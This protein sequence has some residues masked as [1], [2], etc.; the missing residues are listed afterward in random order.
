MIWWVLD[1]PRL[2][3]R[4]RIVIEDPTEQCF[5]SAVTAFEIANKVRTGKLPAAAEIARNMEWIM[6]ENSF[7]PLAVTVEHSLLAGSMDGSHR[8]PFDRLL[9]AQSLIEKIPLITIDREFKPFG[10]ETVW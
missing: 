6:R 1:D 5:V 10:V 2:S 7:S 3:R 8:D 4:A 9:A